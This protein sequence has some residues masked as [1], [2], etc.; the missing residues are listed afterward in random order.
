MPIAQ[1]RLITQTNAALLSLQALN[2][3]RIFIRTQSENISQ[4]GMSYELAYTELCSLI[5]DN[6]R[7]F[8]PSPA[9][10]PDLYE[11]VDVYSRIVHVITAELQ[12]FSMNA[13]KNRA[14]QIRSA[15]KRDRERPDRKQRRQ[16]PH[17]VFESSQMIETSN[18]LPGF[19]S[20]IKQPP[21]YIPP[22]QTDMTAEEWELAQTQISQEQ[23][24]P[25]IIKPPTAEE[26]IAG[27][28]PAHDEPE[29]VPDLPD[30]YDPTTPP[31]ANEWKDL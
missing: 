17:S 16:R 18:Q 22:N 25:L 30:D 9:F 20:P 8:P 13:D 26:V 24:H 21:G 29:T 23:A 14:S 3:I 5:E 12:H 31:P 15:R 11:V 6:N 7:L 1:S 10:A 2:T 27:L 4:R 19:Y 28:K